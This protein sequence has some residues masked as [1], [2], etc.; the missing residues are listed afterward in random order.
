MESL[1]TRIKE[2]VRCF[3][4]FFNYLLWFIL[5]PSKFKKINKKEIKK[6][7]IIS[8]GAIGELLILTPLIRAVKKELNCEISCMIVS[9]NKNVFK[10]NPYISEIIID[11]NNFKKNVENLKKRKF[12]LVI[13][14]KPAS[15]KYSLMCLLAKIKYQLGSGGRGMNLEKSP[16]LFFNKNFFTRKK[17]HVVEDNLD[18]IKQIGINN[19]NPNIEFYTSKKEE[20]EAEKKLK[21][22]KI[23]DYVIIHPGASCIIKVKYPV[24]LWPLERYSKVID[25]ILKNYKV[26]VLIT[27]SEKEKEFADKIKKKVKEN[28]RVINFCGSL[29]LEEL[30]HIISKSKLIIAPNTS[31]SHFA[32]VYKTPFIELDGV[33]RPWQWFPWRKD[34]NYSTLYH[35]EVCT[36][37]NGFSCRKKTIECMKAISVNEVKRSIKE[38]L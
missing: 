17:Q 38:L 7:L 18:I 30:A 23:K 12:D 9:E 34:K 13:I 33:G 35:N 24:K 31:V 5:S 6:V 16:P 10:H 3:F 36:G 20:Q 19:K 2:S 15:F 8:H 4:L 25:F 26:N 29:E 22:N 28:E 32:S 21:K 14:T 27:G 37:C 11:K 1:S